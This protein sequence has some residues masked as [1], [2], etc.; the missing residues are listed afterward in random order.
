M[1][2][3]IFSIVIL[4]TLLASWFI[5]DTTNTQTIDGTV[6]S[7]NNNI[8]KISDKNNNQYTFNYNTS[9]IV[10]NS[11]VTIKYRVSS[12]KIISYKEIKIYNDIPTSWID[13]GIFSKYYNLAYKK[14][15]TL[16]L[17]EKIG[18]LF[19]VR[20]NS[21]NDIKNLKKY[22][23]GGYIFYKNDFD[24]KKKQKYKI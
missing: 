10:I 2:R 12:N 4:L 5:Y 3:I 15:N 21:K 22:K 20:Y 11:K 23:F 8:L 24:N 14:L 18:Q 17:E 6:L 7:A 1:K 19:L 13:N 16:T 9:D